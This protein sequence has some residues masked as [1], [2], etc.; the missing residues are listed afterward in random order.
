MQLCAD[1]CVQFKIQPTFL[2][3]VEIN[4]CVWCAVLF[5][6][7]YSWHQASTALHALSGA[8]TQTASSSRSMP[9]MRLL[10]WARWRGHCSPLKVF[11]AFT[12][13]L[14][15]LHCRAI[16]VSQQK[17]GAANCGLIIYLSVLPSQCFVNWQSTD[18]KNHSRILKWWWVFIQL[19]LL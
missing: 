4:T 14:H 7:I 6:Y 1:V 5:V 16:M 8:T 11:D 19:W 2:L 9:E 18:F 15:S 3:H 13:I 10:H 12:H 17:F